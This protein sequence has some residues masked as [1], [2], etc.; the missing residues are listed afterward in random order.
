VQATDTNQIKPFF[1]PN[2]ITPGRRDGDNDQFV[3]NGIGKFA[4]N[5]IT[6][7]NRYGD[8]V[9]EQENYANNWSAE[10][11]LGGSYY[12]V[13]ITRDSA[14]NERTFKGWIQVIK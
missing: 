7:F 14:G 9:F 1:I 2:V 13:L 10:G 11:L 12:Y 4:S 6:I 3:I 8:H 5:K